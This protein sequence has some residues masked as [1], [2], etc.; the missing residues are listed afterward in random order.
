MGG[1]SSDT[2]NVHRGGGGKTPKVFLIIINLTRGQFPKHEIN[3]QS[4]KQ[5]ER[6]WPVNRRQL[7]YSATPAWRSPGADQSTHIA[8]NNNTLLGVLCLVHIGQ[9]TA[10]LPHTHTLYSRSCFTPPPPA[11]FFYER[12]GKKKESCAPGFLLLAGWR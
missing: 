10:P 12:G 2:A 4:I 8:A 11:Y 5:A 6:K 7:L 3:S 1:S 9:S